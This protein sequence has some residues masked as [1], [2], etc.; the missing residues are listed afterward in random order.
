MLSS[1]GFELGLNITK[2]LSAVQKVIII[3]KQQNTR[4]AENEGN[5]KQRTREKWSLCFFVFLLLLKLKP[6]TLSL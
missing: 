1:I 4:I 3:Y 6:L 2:A 5:Q